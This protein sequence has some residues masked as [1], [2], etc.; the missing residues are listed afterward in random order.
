MS[1]VIPQTNKP[2]G[3]YVPVAIHAGLAYVSGQLPRQGETL[4]YK[5][6]CGAEVDVEAGQAAA[7]LCADL[8]VAALIEAV[9]GIEKIERVL[10]VTGYVASA[11]GF[12][13]QSQV[14][15][16]AS[17]RLVELLGEKGRHARTSIGVAELPRGAPVEINLVAAVKT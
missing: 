12:T 5:G 3:N 6:K 14:M 2:G 15:N 4:L 8:C 7:S 10:H 1:N 13:Q 11:P 17:D 9:G 16:G